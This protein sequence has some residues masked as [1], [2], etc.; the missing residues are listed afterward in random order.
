MF[1]RAVLFSV[2]PPEKVLLPLKVSE[3][4]PFFTN[5]KLPVPRVPENV[6]F[7]F[8][9]PVVNTGEPLEAT[10]PLPLSEPQVKLKVAIASRP[11]IVAA[12]D[13]LVIATRVTVSPAR[14]TTSSE[15]PGTP[16]PPHV[17]DTFQFP[18]WLDVNTA[19]CAVN[20]E[21]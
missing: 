18:F 10:L 9:A 2:I 20:I 13:M 8:R 3:P 19:A 6:V 5:E 7:V 4:V 16:A 1:K 21:K 17:A 12:P 11:L 14:I 15:A